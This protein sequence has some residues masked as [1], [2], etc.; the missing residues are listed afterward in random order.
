MALGSVASQTGVMTVAA[1][2]SG[3]QLPSSRRGRRPRRPGTTE[4]HMATRA[5]DVGGGRQI[6][7]V[8]ANQLMDLA[9]T[10]QHFTS[11]WREKS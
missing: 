7:K 8:I 1:S 3:K 6:E 2:P 5:G 4:L 11:S 10:R 9:T